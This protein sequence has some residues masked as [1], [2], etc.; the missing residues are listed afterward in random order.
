MDESRVMMAIAALVVACFLCF[1]AGYL[2][3][4]T[5]REPRESPQIPSN[6]RPD[7]AVSS[8]NLHMC[9][10][11]LAESCKKAEANVAH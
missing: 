4:A 3:G 11:T 6:Y 2:V 8:D 9:L 7:A 1:G 5:G 10:Q